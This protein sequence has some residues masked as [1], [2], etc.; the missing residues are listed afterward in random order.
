M[1][2]LRKWKGKRVKEKR[3]PSRNIREGYHFMSLWILD[4]SQ[5]VTNLSFRGR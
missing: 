1:P 3:E 5:Q 4:L 2:L